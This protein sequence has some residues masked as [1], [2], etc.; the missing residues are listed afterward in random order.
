MGLKRGQRKDPMTTA[1]KV[2][3]MD[4]NIG[5]HDITTD[6]DTFIN[7]QDTLIEVSLEGMGT[8]RLPQAH[9]PRP[10]SPTLKMRLLE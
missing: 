8:L 10:K 1:G 2:L 5:K 4:A 6:P 3:W 7:D 9:P